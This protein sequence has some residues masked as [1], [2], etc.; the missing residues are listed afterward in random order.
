MNS[1]EKR[2]LLKSNDRILTGVAGGFAEYLNLD[3]TLMRLIFAALILISH[4]LGLIV[5]IIL[6]FAMSDKSN[7]QKGFFSS[8]RD[9]MRSQTQSDSKKRKE[10]KNVEEKD[11]PDDK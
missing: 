7:Y 9:G 6:A 11:V 4:G 5:Y 2:K 3:K 10:I 1:N 8:M